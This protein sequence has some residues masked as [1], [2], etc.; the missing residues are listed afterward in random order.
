M[1]AQEDHDQLPPGT[2]PGNCNKTPGLGPGTF[3]AR[4]KHGEVTNQGIINGTAHLSAADQAKLV[5]LPPDGEFYTLDLDSIG[6]DYRVTAVPGRDHDVLITGLPLAEMEATLRRVEVAE[7]AAFSAALVL[8]GLLGTGF[9]RLSLVPLRRVAAT[10]T[11]VTQLPLASGQVTLP[12]RVPGRQPAH[13]GRP[14]RR[15]VQPDARPRRGG[16]GPPGRL[17]GP[18][19][20]LRRRR[21]PRTA[22][23]AGRHPRLRRTRAAPPRPGPRRHRA[24]AAAASKPNPPG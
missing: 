14:G 4:V 23:P 24:R 12:D 13:R 5:A 7:V 20:P 15:G 21:Q 17:R 3:G 6:G 10:A 9:V 8:T 18:A 1:E 2:P 22:H 16:A 11:R 19:A